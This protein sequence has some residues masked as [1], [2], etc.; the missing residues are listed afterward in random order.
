MPFTTFIC[1]QKPTDG[2]QKQPCVSG[3]I[4]SGIFRSVS[5]EI[6]SG[7]AA[8]Y[9]N[10]L[11][12]HPQV[13]NLDATPSSHQQQS[14]ST[15]TRLDQRQR[16][17]QAPEPE[18]EPERKTDSAPEPKTDPECGVC[19]EPF[20]ENKPQVCLPC[21]KTRDGNIGR[22]CIMCV[23]CLNQ[24]LYDSLAVVRCPLCRK[25]YQ[26][27]QLK[28]LLQ[29]GCLAF[30]TNVTPVH[31][32]P[33]WNDAEEETVPKKRQC[34]ERLEVQQWPNKVLDVEYITKHLL[35]L[36]KRIIHHMRG[37]LEA[38]ML[39]RD[40]ALAVNEAVTLLRTVSFI[41]FPEEYEQI[42]ILEYSI[43]PHVNAFPVKM[44]NVLNSF[45]YWFDYYSTHSE[46]AQW[47]NLLVGGIDHEVLS[48]CSLTRVYFRRGGVQ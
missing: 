15:I 10:I 32:Y 46:Q 11:A 28:Q 9:T 7:A 16:Q 38:N 45:V 41:P 25:P 19:L 21:Y 35:R 24:L 26:K 17:Y 20:N 1:K 47:N 18:P 5:T 23:T 33:F 43:S 29:A 4:P 12:P 2:E 48:D 31:N 22:H 13:W 37:I 36:C 14:T 6:Y 44:D 30:P 39:T 34:L 42:W 27:T 40:D 8:D 3:Y